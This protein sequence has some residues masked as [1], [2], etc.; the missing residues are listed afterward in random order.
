VIQIEETH[1]LFDSLEEMLLPESL[2]SLLSKPVSRVTRQ[3]IDNHNGVAGGRLSYVDTDNDRY[4]LKRMSIES[5]WIMHASDD[6]HGRS[7]RL[8]QY[9][10][11]DRLRPFLEHK[12]IACARDGDGWAILMHDLGDGVHW[13]GQPTAA[14]SVPQFL[15]ALARMHATFWNDPLLLENRVGLCDPARLLDQSAL[16]VARHHPNI[17]AFNSPI[18]VWVVEGWEIMSKLLEREIFEAM[19]MLIENPSPLFEALD[20]YPFTLLHG[21]YRDANLAVLVQGQLVAYDWQ[22]AAHSLMTVDLAWFTNDVRDL[23]TLSQ[24]QSFYRERLERYLGQEFDNQSWEVMLDL[25]YLVNALR[26]TC[27]SAYFSKHWD[28]PTWREREKVKVKEKG[29]QTHRALRWLSKQ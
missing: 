20:R 16:P 23:I 12:M 1:K 19:H 13:R 15:D 24:A 2:S 22:E 5:D 10:M 7:V 8:W 29:Q 17:S 26:S 14:E 4:V 25:G 11:L 27:F 21:D 9:G 3:P 28:N 6:R 18:P